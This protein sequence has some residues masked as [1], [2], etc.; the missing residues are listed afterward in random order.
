[1][2]RATLFRHARD[3]KFSGVR[4]PLTG[5]SL[6]GRVL[7]AACLLH[8]WTC[9]G[10]SAAL[11]L[12]WGGPMSYRMTTSLMAALVALAA[13]GRNETPAAATHE[14][15]IYVEGEGSEGCGHRAIARGKRVTL[16]PGLLDLN[17]KALAHV[18]AE[19][20]VV[21]AEGKAV[22]L[23]VDERKTYDARGY[24]MGAARAYRMRFEHNGTFFVTATY[25]DGTTLE[26]QVAVVD[27]VGIRLAEYGREL[28]TSDEGR[29]CSELLAPGGLPTL[30]A[31]Q[32]LSARLVPIDLRG[33]PLVGELELSFAG[34]MAVRPA[35]SGPWFSW[36][37]FGPAG[38]SVTVTDVALQ[39]QTVVS[40]SRSSSVA[41]CSP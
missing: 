33:E 25:P 21:D 24:P 26:R 6:A 4:L 23:E 27:Q 38:E 16:M 3:E 1:V 30:A 36:Y 39:H 8:R 34:S 11:G 7:C 29:T 10:L 5:V 31:N 13:C 41:R 35:F 20:S 28:I 18:D 19:L 2:S 15:F 17:E 32:E 37:T 9:D 40:L 14:H 12:L 22:A